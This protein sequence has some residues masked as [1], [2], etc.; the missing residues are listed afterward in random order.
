MR[1]ALKSLVNENFR[2]SAWGALTKTTKAIIDRR[3]IVD[4]KGDK[5]TS[6]DF[7]MLLC[8]QVFQKMIRTASA[9]FKTKA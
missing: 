2:L 9:K 1:R 4:D 5:M 6:S 7:Y 8:S 3:F